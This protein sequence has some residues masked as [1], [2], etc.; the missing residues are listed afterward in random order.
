VVTDTGRQ[1]LGEASG[2]VVLTPVDGQGSELR[3]PVHSN[4]KPS[5][6]LTATTSEDGRT[7]ALSGQGIA[8]GP[9]FEPQSYTS[10]VS[11]FERLGASPDMPRCT[12]R[13]A[14]DCYRSELERSVDLAAV[15]ITSDVAQAGADAGLYVAVS[16]VGKATT[17]QSVVN[18]NVLID[19][20]GDGAWDY[21]VTTVR[22][23][24]LDLPLVVVTDRQFHPLPSIDA[25]FVAP[26]NLVNGSVDTNVFDTDVQV[27]GVPLSV[28]PLVTGRMSFGVVS[29]SAYGSVDG[30]GAFLDPL[31]NPQLG[32]TPMSFDP[33]HPGLSFT[34]A[35]GSAA[36]LLPAADGTTLTVT[37]NPEAYA[38]D[39]AIGGAQKGAMVVLPHN[40]T[41]TGRTQSVP[42]TVGKQVP[43]PVG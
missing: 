36:L 14:P 28:L 15:G 10:L 4:A 22:L 21:D 17:P 8:N 38:A 18:Y 40:D 24:K 41:T 16:S 42:V 3:V 13:L 7:V 19:G 20:D 25:P 6:T 5:S 31:G 37:Q 39:V 35:D 34:G 12:T 9:A 33:L 30:L 2:R 23:P 27:L 29:L 26:L 43:V 32:G 11:A 1:F